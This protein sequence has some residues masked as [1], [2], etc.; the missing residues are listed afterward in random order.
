MNSILAVIISLILVLTAL[1][2][3]IATTMWRKVV[4][5]NTKQSS[6][7]VP[8]A[9][10]MPAAGEFFGGANE[11]TQSIWNDDIYRRLLTLAL[12]AIPAPPM[13]TYDDIKVELKYRKAAAPPRPDNH[14]GQRKLFLN[15]LLV[16]CDFK[17]ITGDTLDDKIIVYAGGAPSNHIYYLHNLFP[18]LKILIVDPNEV[19]IYKTASYIND[20]LNV[21]THYDDPSDVV[22]FRPGRYDMYYQFAGRKHTA[23]DYPKPIRVYDF[24]SKAV[25]E[26]F[27][28]TPEADIMGR[29]WKPEF[30]DEMFEIIQSSPDHIFIVED[31]F[32]LELAQNMSK[33]GD[34]I[35][36]FSDIRTNLSSELATGDKMPT[37][38]DIIW[39]LSQ[40]F[41]WLSIVK[42]R[43]SMWKFRCPFNDNPE[44]IDKHAG[45]S[46]VK[47][48][49]DMSKKHGIDF[50]ADNKRGYVS[51]PPGIIYIQ[52]FA[53][54][55][56]TESRLVIKSEDIESRAKY[57]NHEYEDKFYAYNNIHRCFIEHDHDVSEELAKYGVDKCN[58][59]ALERYIWNRYKTEFAPD[60][61]IEK[62]TIDLCAFTARKLIRGGHGFFN[63]FTLDWYT[64]MSKQ[65]ADLDAREK[66]RRPEPLDQSILDN[67]ESVITAAERSTP[68]AGSKK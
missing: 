24:E 61:D 59:C 26:T 58:D 16:L 44:L 46:F 32:T 10:D 56:S 66:G 34:K 7:G 48:D 47:P 40:Q 65:R 38:L 4:N 57:D 28:T 42:P 62:A 29:S 31:F 2:V 35:I 23:A 39:N 19:H 12:E 37:D 17:E 43:L 33:Y 52:P 21:T 53:G 51:Y 1:I 41:N 25:V 55:S 67:I 14:I 54:V 60:L 64:K 27:K 50:V 68:A 11:A 22:Y 9:G 36:F 5:K 30:T 63:K 45:I 3:D 6:R 13:V 15:E 8:G 20:R 18:A 49:L